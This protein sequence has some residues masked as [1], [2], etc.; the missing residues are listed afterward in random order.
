MLKLVNIYNL[1]AGDIV[2]FTKKVK[3]Y[4]MMNRQRMR[5]LRG[6]IMNAWGRCTSYGRGPRLR[7]LLA[8]FWN[9]K[10]TNKITI[11]QCSFTTYLITVC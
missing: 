7:R 2:L 9:G 8:L 1:L 4:N 11:T 6:D 3:L 10:F 5:L